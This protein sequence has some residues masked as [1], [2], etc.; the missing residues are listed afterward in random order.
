MPVKLKIVD[1]GPCLLEGDVEVLDAKGNKFDNGGKKVVALCRCGQSATKP[2]CDGTHN[3]IG[4]RSEVRA[5]L[6]D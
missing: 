5:P 2:F 4:F 1:N 6:P 3:K